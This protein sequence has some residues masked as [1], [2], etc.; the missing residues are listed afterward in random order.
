MTKKI[1][2]IGGIILMLAIFFSCVKTESI[3]SSATT[4]GKSKIVFFPSIKVNGETL[5]ILYVGDTYTDEGASAILDEK[6]YEYTTVGSV[7]VTTPGVYQL[8]YSAVNAEGFAVSDF[9]TVVVI[10]GNSVAANDFSGT[11]ARYVDGVANGQTSTWTKTGVGVYA[12]DNPGG[13]AGLTVT[14]VNFDGKKVTV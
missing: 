10:D 13:A 4:V 6:P 5:I 2:Q 8:D 11:Y 3:S 1:K 7:D 9:R 14:G 12:I